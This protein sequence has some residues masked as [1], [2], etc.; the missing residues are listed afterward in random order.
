MN[1]SQVT[2]MGRQ[3]VGED[4]DN[5]YQF[6][7]HIYKYM[8][9]IGE[10]PDSEKAQAVRTTIIQDISQDERVFTCVSSVNFSLHLQFNLQSDISFLSI[11]S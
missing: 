4:N 5:N 7:Y 6:F 9:G 1:C 11:F 3:L 10:K 8:V 2:Q